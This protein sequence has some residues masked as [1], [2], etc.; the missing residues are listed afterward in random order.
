MSK[1]IIFGWGAPKFKEQF[2]ELPDAVAEHFDKDN[3]AMIRL[4]VRGYTTD[5]ARTAT[6]KKLS[7]AISNAVASATRPTGGSDAD[8]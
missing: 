6:M 7:K 1:Q 2:P 3:E 5:S 8:A 4:H